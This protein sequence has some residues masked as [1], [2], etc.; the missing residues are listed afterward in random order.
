MTVTTSVALAFWVGLDESVTCTFTV[1]V[2]A[3]VGCPL[4]TPVARLRV[5][6]WGNPVADH[7]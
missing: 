5:S 1:D 6:P 4:I 2:P 3:L 7:V